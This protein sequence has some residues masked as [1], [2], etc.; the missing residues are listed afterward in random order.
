MLSK[1]ANPRCVASFRYLHSGRLFQFETRG[2]PQTEG[3]RMPVQSVEFFWL[4]EE[5]ATRYRLVS[6]NDGGVRVIPFSRHSAS[7]S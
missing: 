6:N 7:A 5:C 1:C 4:C 3:D 2:R